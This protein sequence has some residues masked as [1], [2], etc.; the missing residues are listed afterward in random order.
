MYVAVV[1]AVFG[2]AMIFGSVGLLLYG[3]ALWAVMAAFV[4][5]YEEPTLQERYGQ[6]YVRYCA[7]VRAWLPRVRP[8]HPDLDRVNKTS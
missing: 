5:W 4:H 6:E 7:A 3:I 1:S 8:W 2:Q